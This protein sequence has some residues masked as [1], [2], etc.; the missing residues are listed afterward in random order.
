MF[1]FEYEYINKVQNIYIKVLCDKYFD[2]AAAHHPTHNSIYTETPSM[3]LYLFILG[4]YRNKAYTINGT[5]T[6]Y[7]YN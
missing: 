5:R 2:L 1:E 3:R 7:I 4:T 6:V